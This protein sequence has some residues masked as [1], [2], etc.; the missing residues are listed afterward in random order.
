M[1][2]FE[3]YVVKTPDAE[4]ECSSASN[5]FVQPSGAVELKVTIWGGGGLTLDGFKILM[6][7]YNAYLAG[8]TRYRNE[9]DAALAGVTS[10]QEF[11]WA[12]DTDVGIGGDKH[13]MT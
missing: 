2:S 12:S 4:A 6:A 13:I 8:L 10:G 9:E 3:A 1:N 7:Q 5:C 11:L